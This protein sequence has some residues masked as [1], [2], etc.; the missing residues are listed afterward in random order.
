MIDDAGHFRAALRPAG[1]ALLATATSVDPVRFRVDGPRLLLVDGLNEIWDPSD[2]GLSFEMRLLAALL[3]S[4]HIEDAIEALGFRLDETILGMELFEDP[5]GRIPVQQI[6]GTHA[7]IRLEP[8]ISRPR[9]ITIVSGDRTYEARADQYGER[10]NGW[11][12]TEAS[13]TVNGRVAL[14]LSV[15]DLA[16]T[17]SDLAPLGGPEPVVQESVRLPRLPL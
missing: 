15:T 17:T 2:E 3:G 9:S 5:T 13:V 1:N 12:P 16:P 7:W 11:F 8:G 10:G 14:S 6:G 4:N